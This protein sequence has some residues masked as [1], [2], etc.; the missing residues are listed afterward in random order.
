MT[1]SRSKDQHDMEHSSTRNLHQ[2]TYPSTSS[3]Q[4]ART[5]LMELSVEHAKRTIA[6]EQVSRA[7]SNCPKDP[8]NRW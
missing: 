6:L 8:N 5:R 7:L 4:E 2:V 1:C 3:R